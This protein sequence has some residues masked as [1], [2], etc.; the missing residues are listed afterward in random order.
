VHSQLI[1]VQP[2]VATTVYT[3]VRDA[4]NLKSTNDVV[5]EFVSSVW[6]IGPEVVLFCV[7]LFVCLYCSCVC[8][9]SVQTDILLQCYVDPRSIIA[10]S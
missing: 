4:G 9:S 5:S 10:Y 7:L 6:V 2:A 8:I 1:A 3:P